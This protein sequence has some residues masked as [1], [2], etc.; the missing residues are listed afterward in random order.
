MAYLNFWPYVIGFAAIGVIWVIY[1]VLTQKWNPLALAEGADKR[2]SLSKFQWLLWLWVIAF[3]YVV[4]YSARFLVS[5]GVLDPLTDI[6]AN[7]L[8]ILGFSTGTMALAKGIT[9]AYASGGAIAKENAEGMKAGDLV[10][11]DAGFPD[12]SKLQMFIWTLIAVAIYLAKLIGVVA[13]AALAP[14]TARALDVLAIPDLDSSLMLLSGLVSTGYLAK[15]IVTRDA[16]HIASIT[17]SAAP[18]GQPVKVIVLGKNLGPRKNGSSLNVGHTL[19]TPVEAW[20]DGRINATFPARPAAGTL[21][22]SVIV[23]G[24]K[25]N[26]VTLQVS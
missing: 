23:A 11:D 2:I 12:L 5:G 14:N 9:Q 22:V 1:A 3:T 7:I 13:S 25:S 21:L 18:A 4:I 15:K 20:T 17:P 19:D 8:L 6:P 26:E 24:V 16:P 10:A